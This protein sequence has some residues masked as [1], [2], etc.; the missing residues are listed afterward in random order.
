MN[1]EMLSAESEPQKATYCMIAFTW[2]IQN[3]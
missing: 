2:D 1:L 3:R